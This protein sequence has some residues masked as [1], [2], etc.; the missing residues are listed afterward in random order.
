MVVS[1]ISRLT[2]NENQSNTMCNHVNDLLVIPSESITRTRAKRLKEILNE[3][4]QSTYNEMD[5]EGLK[6]SMELKR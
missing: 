5:L 2:N 4:V 6:K 3:L 1:I